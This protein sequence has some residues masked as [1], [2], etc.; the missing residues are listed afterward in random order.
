[1]FDPDSAEGRDVHAYLKGIDFYLQTVANVTAWDNLYLLR[2]TAS[3]DV[4]SFLDRQL[5]LSK[6]T[7]NNYG[8][9]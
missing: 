5:R 3:S 7:S 8:K 4:R 1:M 6:R 9:L 2:I